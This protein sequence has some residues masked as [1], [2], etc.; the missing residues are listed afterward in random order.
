MLLRNELC[1]SRWCQWDVNP[2]HMIRKYILHY[3]VFNYAAHCDQCRIEL[4]HALQVFKNILS[5][6]KAL[7]V[8][9]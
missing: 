1:L 9:A 5:F 6:I 4:K 8:F 7:H 2:Q 3:Y